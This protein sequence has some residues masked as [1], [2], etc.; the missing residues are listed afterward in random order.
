MTTVLDFCGT[1]RKT[2]MAGTSFVFKDLTTIVTSIDFKIL[3]TDTFQKCDETDY[4]TAME[5]KLI[6]QQ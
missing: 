2:I 1:V 6:Q 4:H 3:N 5:T